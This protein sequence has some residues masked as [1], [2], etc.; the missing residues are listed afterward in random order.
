MTVAHQPARDVRAHPAEADY[1][2]LHRYFRA[3]QS[4][5]PSL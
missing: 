5:Q 4:D 1:A 3:V 2:D